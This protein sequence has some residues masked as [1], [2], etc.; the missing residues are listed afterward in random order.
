MRTQAELRDEI[1]SAARAEFARYGLAGARIDRVA[2]HARA[3]KERL[4][5]HFGDKENLFR[6]VVAADT[7]Q[8]LGAIVPRPDALPEFVGD[9]YDLA[10]AHPEHIRMITW[11]R[12]EELDLIPPDAEM[13]PALGPDVVAA[14][15]EGGHVDP[16]WDPGELL[17]MLFGIGMA[18]A[19]WPDPEA[20][21][22]DAATIAHRRA[23]AVE[24]A[25]RLITPR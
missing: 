18:W 9:I 11:A 14:A 2:K 23:A 13:M 10:R 17:V 8:F 12:L 3:S 6:E 1:L 16:S 4:Y 22:E 5:A 7:A 15:Q 25:A 20:A 19:T 21:T 24:A